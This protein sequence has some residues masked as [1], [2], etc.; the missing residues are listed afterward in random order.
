LELREYDTDIDGIPVHCWEGGTGAPLMLM[1][2]SG[3]GVS[4]LGNWRHVLV[5]LA[6]RYHVLAFDL[7]GFGLSGRKLQPPYFD[8]SLWQRQAAAML[9]RLPDRPVAILA[10]S[11]SAAIALRLAAGEPRIAKLITTGA[12]GGP[13]QINPFLAAAWTNPSNR[14]KLRSIMSAA[15]FDAATLT[16]EFLDNRMAVLRRDDYGA[17][18]ATMFAGDPQKIIDACVVGPELLERIR[19]DVLMLHGREDLM[20]PFETTTLALARSLP[21]ADVVAFGRCRHGVA[22][23]QPTKF[24]HIVRG[25]LG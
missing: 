2:G 13:F 25:F 3:P 19:C 1:H 11:L 14:E 16:D 15:V 23:E 10:H 7:I 8:I 12:M 21:Q 6:Q 9:K 22:Q 17:H 24:L 20:T 18:F 4:T 5:P